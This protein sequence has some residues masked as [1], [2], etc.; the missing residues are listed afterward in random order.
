MSPSLRGSGLKFKLMDCIRQQERCLPLYEGVDWNQSIAKAFERAVS[1]PSLRGSGLKLFPC[2]EIYRWMLC[3]PLYE[4]VDW[5]AASIRYCRN[6]VVSLF[7][8]E[9][10]EIPSRTFWI[11]PKPVSLFTREWIEIVCVCPRPPPPGGLPLYEG[12]DWNAATHKADTIA[13]GLPLYEGVDWNNFGICQH[14]WR[15]S[16]PLYE[17]VDWNWAVSNWPVNLVAVSLFTR[18]WIEIIPASSIRKLFSVSLFTREWIEIGVIILSPQFLGV[19]LFTREWIEIYWD[20]R[21][22]VAASC[23]PLYEGVDWNVEHPERMAEHEP[24]SLFTREWIEIILSFQLSSI[25]VCLPLY[26]GVDWNKNIVWNSWKILCVSLF[27]REWIEIFLLSHG[28]PF[29]PV[30][31]FTREWIEIKKLFPA[32]IFPAASPSLRGSGL[33]CHRPHTPLQRI[34]SPS[35]RGSGLKSVPPDNQTQ[36]VRSPSLRG[37]GLKYHQSQSLRLQRMHVSLF[38]RE[39]I[40]MFCKSSK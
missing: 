9:W 33:K 26:E 16:L 21:N 28:Q 34:R 5:N 7:T 19:S 27:T 18:E 40:E 31:L 20:D 14:F 23:L 2:M 1:S 3:L 25:T 11:L 22:D 4:G 12:V 39:W 32:I 35:L 6:L 30:S 17:G 29:R 37:S 38:T 10:I 15:C 24:V 36:P 13:H 8:R